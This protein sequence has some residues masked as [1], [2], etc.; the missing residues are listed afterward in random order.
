VSSV[1]L[2]ATF[3]T[4]LVTSRIVGP[5]VLTPVV[6]EGI[7]LGL[8]ATRPLLRRPWI[9][10]AWLVLALILPIALEALGV[11]TP[12]W[13]FDGDTMRIRSAVV[14]GSNA[15]REAAL[16]AA[17]LLFITMGVLFFWATSRDRSAAE[18]RLHIQAWHLRHLLPDRTRAQP[19]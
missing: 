4:A 12:T 15:A 10:I 8:M 18:R 19:V 6:I 3:V 2:V 17:H 9:V 14:H 5:F 7:A 1:A 16:I 13:W 11:F